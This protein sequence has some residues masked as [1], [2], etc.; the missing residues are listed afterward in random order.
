MSIG[1]NSQSNM[2]RLQLPPTP[3]AASNVSQG[4]G[5]EKSSF[6]NN[7][8]NMYYTAN[9]TQMGPRR[10]MSGQ[11]SI[12]MQSDQNSFQQ[13]NSRKHSRGSNNNINISLNIH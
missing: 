7:P 8:K 5:L 13:P 3:G 10:N 12:S 9:A 2:D 6:S 1:A 11:G 4:L